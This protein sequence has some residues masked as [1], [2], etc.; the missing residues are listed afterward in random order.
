MKRFNKVQFPTSVMLEDEIEK[1]YIK[2]KKKKEKKDV[3][4]PKFSHQTRND[5]DHEN[6]VKPWKT[7]L[8]N[9]HI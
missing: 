3:C 6:N 4:Q 8:K 1:K 2:F 7:N 9:F 5:T